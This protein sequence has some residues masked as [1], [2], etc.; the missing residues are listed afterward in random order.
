MVAFRVDRGCA[1]PSSDT[2]AAIFHFD[3]STEQIIVL[4]NIKHNR[5]SLEKC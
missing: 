1:R 3:P 4:R 2:A 5:I